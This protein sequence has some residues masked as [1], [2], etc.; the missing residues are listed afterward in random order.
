M[1]NLKNFGGS[2]T[3]SWHNDQV[4]LQKNITKRL[5]ELGINYIL[6]AFAGFV[7]NAIKRL[8]P[9]QNFR[10]S[11]SWSGF[12]CNESC[13]Y[14]NSLLKFKINLFLVIGNINIRNSKFLLSRCFQ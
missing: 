1:G 6:P 14:N 9:D 11:N 2:L 7:P 13:T 8:L 10:I 3:D 5:T 12:S 4:N